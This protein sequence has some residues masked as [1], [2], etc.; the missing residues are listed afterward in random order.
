MSVITPL[1]DTLLHEVLGKP[2]QF[3]LPRD[4]NQPVSATYVAVP[5]RSPHSDSRL[6]ARQPPAPD[7]SA[8]G[9]T[10]RRAAV[11]TAFASTPL[12]T[13]TPAPAQSGVETTFSPAAQRIAEVLAKMPDVAP[14]VSKGAQPL[15]GNVVFADPAR[16]AQSLQQVIDKSGLFFEAHL[17]RWYRG[18]LSRQQLDEQP[19]IRLRQ[20]GAQDDDAL[21]GLMRQQLDLLATPQVR[22][23]GQPWPGLWLQ[24]MIQPPVQQ[25]D[26]WS[27]GDENARRD[28]EAEQ[29]VVSTLVV[30]LDAL[31]RIEAALQLKGTRFDLSVHVDSP[32][33]LVLLR[34]ARAT[35]EERLS[36]LGFEEP[37]IH[38]ALKEG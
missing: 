3:P 9:T 19:Q 37:A 11:D 8:L 36:G 4:L 24:L 10:V 38:L 12:P 34:A 6:D 7:M 23:E 35:L 2:A 32:Q 22:W 27:H 21:K 18:E 1:L 25:R 13:G 17:A 5:G 30:D 26:E 20:E 15:L 16:V 14:L 28:D 31:G 29:G 33:T